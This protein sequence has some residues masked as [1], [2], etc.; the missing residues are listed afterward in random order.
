MASRLT[1][2]LAGLALWLTPA[3]AFAQPRQLS[4]EQARARFEKLMPEAIEKAQT[5]ILSQQRR[6]GSLADD[7]FQHAFVTL[8][9]LES[10][11]PAKNPALQR[12]VD[13]LLKSHN[14]ETPFLALRLEVLIRVRA[15]LPAA[16][17]GPL[18][19]RISVD[20]KDLLLA[21]APNGAFRSSPTS[22]EQ[23]PP[24]RFSFSSF[25][26][27]RF[28][29]DQGFKIS[30]AAL[31][32]TVA[33]FVTLQNSNGGWGNNTK[34]KDLEDSDNFLSL[35]A[36]ACLAA[37]G[38]DQ[39]CREGAAKSDPALADAARAA[40]KYLRENTWGWCRDQAKGN[41][42]R[43]YGFY[44]QV[45]LVGDFLRAFPLERLNPGSVV[46]DFCLPLLARQGEEK[47]GHWNGPVETAF[48][49]YTLSFE[50]RPA[51]VCDLVEADAPLVG[52]RGLL[53]ATE[54]LALAERPIAVR[55]NRGRIGPDFPLWE[56][57]PLGFIDA[58]EKFK[59]ADE[60]KKNLRD[61]VAAGGTL[62]VQI[63]CGKKEALD[64]VTR[65]LQSVWPAVAV[66]PIRSNH[67][68]WF[69]ET[70]V[71]IN[72][73]P[74]VFGLDD[75]VRTFAFL[76]Q[77]NLIG[78]LAAGND[79]TS[80]QVFRNV[81]AYALEG[82]WSFKPLE[83]IS[84]VA[85]SVSAVPV[86][87]QPGE[88]RTV[89]VA[90]IVPG[91]KVDAAPLGYNG[92]AKAGEPITRAAPKFKLLGPKPLAATDEHLAVCDLAWLSV[93]TSTALADDEQAGLKK[94]V[95][96]GGFLV[97]E[98]RLG[99]EAADKA[100]RKIAEA[101]G[102]QIEPARGLPVLTGQFGD[103]TKGYDVSK[104]SV[105]KGGKLF[106][107]TETDLRLLTLGGKTVGVYSPLDLNIS[108]SGIRCWGLRGYSA[109]EARE[110]LA[111]ILIFRTVK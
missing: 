59:L 75:G 97:L 22:G 56:K 33:L 109:G 54:R 67:P 40:A 28:C 55:Y 87:P 83:F 16:A 13:Y 94:Y 52:N 24:A 19:D 82:D 98:A 95:A 66:Q 53:A 102:L 9:L 80:L 104:T 91:G 5:F 107:P 26:A 51:L 84:S 32:K 47:D 108:A 79:P 103:E 38:L 29:A 71:S 1:I 96:G 86:T 39:S 41:D 78:D 30:D 70:S 31:K 110:I 60:E 10:G 90:Q 63:H 92:W 76:F 34:A 106:P 99:D 57:T 81:A 89:G 49:L 74:V 8:S 12:A 18:D 50:A 58:T 68:F 20:L 105:R 37:C 17:R 65:E 93:T 23:N 88:A 85:T 2:L 44:R 3:V 43:D 25:A 48:A 35:R 64:A 111:N 6:D 42:S 14:N 36:M 15:Q 77:K 61:Y 11:L 72:S 45:A 101:L 46:R 21:Q 27:L 62:I 100:A 73:R 7:T 69:A 4:E